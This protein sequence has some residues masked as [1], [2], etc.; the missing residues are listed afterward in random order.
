VYFYRVTLDVT[1]NYTFVGS[2]S[3][4]S[5]ISSYVKRAS[6]QFG[7]TGV[8]DPIG[9]AA[10]AEVTLNN[11]DGDFMLE[12][13]TAKYY[14]KIRRGTML[15]LEMSTNGSAWTQMFALKIQQIIPQFSFDGAYEVTLKC[16]DITSDFLNQDFVAPL[17]TDVRV[18]EI[19]DRLHETAKAIW[20]YESYYQFIGHTSIGDGRSPFDGSVWTDF[21]TGE[22]ALP[23]Y[24]DNLDKGL[25]VKVQQYI[26]DAVMAEIFGLYYFSP[27]SERFVFLSRYHASDTAVS[28][29][30]VNTIMDAPRYTYA[31]DLVNDFSLSYY[32]RAI[33]AENSV[34]YSSDNVPFSV[35]ARGTK[36]LTL[37]YRD[38]DNESASVG[39]FVVDDLVVDTDIVF[40][41]QSDGSGA[42][43]KRFMTTTLIKGAA[44]S[45]LVISNRKRSSPAYVTT[46]QLRGTP[47]TTYNKEIAYGYNDDS[48]FGLG[49][50]QSTG[51]DRASG[52]ESLYAVSDIDFAQDYADYKVAAYG[53]PQQVIEKL[54]IPV[55]QSDSATEA[56]VLARTIGDVINVTDDIVGHDMDYMIVGEMHNANVAG[57]THTASYLIRP[58]NR[59]GFFVW[60]ESTYGG[61]DI[62]SF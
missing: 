33:G 42:N 44:S 43:P 22:T 9:S 55:K 10:Y 45:E 27:R 39:A 26:K 4:P 61:N 58:S 46:L 15:K 25:G 50:D 30:V 6:W 18:D 16:S 62:F 49:S 51:N 41:T 8:Y 57:Q 34:L 5:D 32:P 36:R 19:L 13:A 53:Q 12:K 38:P 23:F 7:L 56:Q 59:S 40:N 2:G 35:P 37:K 24:G 28:W 11:A 1:R 60:D 54:V 31:R 21:E 52:S 3:A 48:V 14:G 47:I 20:P 17:Q 29:D